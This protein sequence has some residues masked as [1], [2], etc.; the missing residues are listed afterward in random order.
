M[1]CSSYLTT[2][3]FSHSS[4]TTDLLKAIEK[5]P[6]RKGRL[7]CRKWTKC[8]QTRR[9]TSGV[10]H[11][12][13]KLLHIQPLRVRLHQI[14]SCDISELAPLNGQF[15]KEEQASLLEKGKSILHNAKFR[16]GFQEGVFFVDSEGPLPYRVQCLKSGTCSCGCNFFNRNNLCFHCLAVA[17]RRGCVQK[18]VQA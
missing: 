1:P 13:S 9:L 3:K 7:L 15:S 11:S 12:S 8:V 17:I 4:S 6:L 2:G 14:K 10:T 5:W 18:V 16:E